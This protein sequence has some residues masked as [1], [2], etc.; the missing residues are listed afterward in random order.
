[1]EEEEEEEEVGFRAIAAVWGH[2][3]G[4]GFVGSNVQNTFSLTPH[5]CNPV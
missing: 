1:M 5:L 3:L 2:E 4:S